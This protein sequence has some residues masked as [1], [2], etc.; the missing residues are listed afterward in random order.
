MKELVK[1]VI[2]QGMRG[3]ASA[4]GLREY[5]SGISWLLRNLRVQMTRQ[6]AINRDL[7]VRMAR[8]EATNCQLLQQ[9]AETQHCWAG[10]NKGVQTLL[11]WKYK[12][13]FGKGLTPPNLSEVE[14]RCFSQTGED[15]IL[16][17]LFSLLGTTDKRCVEVCA[18]D[19][20]ECNTANLI[21]NHGWT[22]LLLDGDESLIARGKAF[23]AKCQD[24]FLRPPTLVATWISA[25]NINSLLANHCYAGDMDLLSLDMDGVD[26]WI[27]KAMDSIRPRVVVLE[28]QSFWGP[29]RAVTIP[30]REDFRHQFT[31]E[32]S[33][34]LGASLPAFVKLGR[35]KGYRLVG[36]HGH[37]FNA[38]FVR[39]GIGEDVLPEIPTAQCYAEHPLLKHWVPDL[40][41]NMEG[42]GWEWVE[43]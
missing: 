3:A 21:V 36:V 35:E 29:E 11:S 18:G 1:R 20:I 25:A 6:E 17:Y 15:G 23:Y 32:P 28:F 2:K 43:V 40:I 7:C 5:L 22:G 33:Y 19:G 30:Y 37:D 14:L 16:L 34:Y 12:E 24:T 26:Y 8:Q 38:F 10:A 39:N 27:W 13:L 9:L 31:K 41:P 42:R 4:V